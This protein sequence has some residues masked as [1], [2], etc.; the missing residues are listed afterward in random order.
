MA[1]LGALCNI[2]FLCLG[3]FFFLEIFQYLPKFK[4]FF[5]HEQ[6]FPTRITSQEDEREMVC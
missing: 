6:M 1:F 2:R 3:E 4:P 5:Y